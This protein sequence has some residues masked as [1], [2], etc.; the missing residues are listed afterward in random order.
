MIVV[1]VWSCGLVCSVCRENLSV[2][3]C[4]VYLWNQS[5]RVDVAQMGGR[6]ADS[7]RTNALFIVGGRSCTPEVSITADFVRYFAGYKVP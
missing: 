1:Y 2:A 3:M 4:H 7:K 5:D 6:F